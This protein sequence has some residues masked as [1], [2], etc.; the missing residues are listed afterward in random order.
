MALGRSTLMSAISGN[1]GDTEFAMTKDG[2]VMKKRKPAKTMN[3]PAEISARR[4]FQEWAQ[5][6]TDL[7]A[8]QT[9][10]F[11]AYAKTH[12]ITDRLGTV[13]NVSG[14]NLFMKLRVPSSPDYNP[15]V[16][17]EPPLLTTGNYINA[18]AMLWA[19]GPYWAFASNSHAVESNTVESVWIARFQS[20]TET[21]KPQRWIPITTMLRPVPWTDFYDMACETCGALCPGE[22]IALK[23]V[24]RAPGYWPSMPYILFSTVLPYMAAWWD[25]NDNGPTAT[26][27]DEKTVNNAIMVD[28]TGDPNTDAHTVTG[29]IYS[30]LYLDGVDD[31]IELPNAITV[32]TLAAGTDFT[33]AFWWKPDSPNPAASKVILSNSTPATYGLTINT[34]ADIFYM[35]VLFRDGGDSHSYA[36]AAETPVAN[37]WYHFAISRKGTTVEYF[38]DGVS[39]GSETHAMNSLA[40]SDAARSLLIGA[41]PTPDRWAPGA[42]DDFRLY[43]HCLRPDEIAALAAM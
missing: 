4:T 9:R 29:H 14:R 24:M 3:S 31:Y 41:R 30:A 21:H 1:V 27:Y 40:L 43:A 26:V 17:V 38:V 5:R 36:V 15:F 16:E 2:M 32:P 39:V 13:K 42:V 37:I 33:I 28:P 20:P 18:F 11:N 6:W 7:T 23:F 12:P 10:A 19:G 35:S 25:M 8:E 34:I 22:H